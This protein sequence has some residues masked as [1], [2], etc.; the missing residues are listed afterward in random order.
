MT[1]ALE[2]TLRKALSR[3]ITLDVSFGAEA[4][5]TM[6]FGPSGVIL[7]P[8]TLATTV[9]LLETWSHRAGPADTR[10]ERGANDALTPD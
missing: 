4:G 7:G 2:V 8:A 9:A 1:I 6:L 3:E 10:K 5:I